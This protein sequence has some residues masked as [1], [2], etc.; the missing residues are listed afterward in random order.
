MGAIHVGVLVSL[1]LGRYTD[2]YHS[3]SLQRRSTPHQILFPGNSTSTMTNLSSSLIPARTNHYHRTR[4]CSQL[5]AKMSMATATATRPKRNDMA[6]GI[7]SW[8]ISTP[9]AAWQISRTRRK[10][11]F[12]MGDLR[13]PEGIWVRRR[14]SFWSV[15]LLPQRSFSRIFATTRAYKTSL[16]SSRSSWSPG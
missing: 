7:F 16:S 15:N 5:T 6:T 14:A 3:N 2:S 8:E 10:T 4:N 9:A 1:H 11:I 12:E 13:L